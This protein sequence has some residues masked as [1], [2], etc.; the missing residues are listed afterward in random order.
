[1]SEENKNKQNVGNDTIHNVSC[2]YYNSG[3]ELGVVGVSPNNIKHKESGYIFLAG[4]APKFSWI[5][6]SDLYNTREECI[7]KPKATFYNEC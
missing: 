4:R 5:K 7:G 1:M 3:D 2:R 6:E